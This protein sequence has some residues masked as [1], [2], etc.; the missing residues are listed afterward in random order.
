MRVLQVGMGG[1]GRNWTERVVPQV[2]AV[3]LVGY[4]DS[5]P[6]VL[7]TAQEQGLVA[8]KDCYISL[9]EALEKTDPDAVL[10]TAALSGHVPI[11]RQALEAGK[12]V[13][14]EKPFAPSVREGA[15]LV[16]LAERRHL[17][18]MVSQNYRFRPAVRAV[19]DIVSAGTLGALHT[20]NID[21]RKFSTLGPNGRSPH[22]SLAEP[23]LVDMS[24]HHFD[25]L[26]A[27]LR[28]QPVEIF[29]R[30][31][32]P[33][34]SWFDGPA[35]GTAVISFEGDLTVSYRGSWISPGPLT[36]WSGEWRMEFEQGEVWWTSQGPSADTPSEEYVVLRPVGQSEQLVE[37]PP[38]DLVDRAGSLAE[39]VAAVGSSRVPESSGA[40]NLGSLA[41]MYAAVDSAASRAAVNITKS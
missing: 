24:I 10:V 36:P 23:L 7:T 41:L 18:L 25:L 27:V 17:T 20:V 26:R 11:A 32:N 37:L 4:V 3:E 31:W 14:V 5:N 22:H 21:F 30:T 19:Q 1:W 6:A 13:L 40:E 8:T 39:F 2:S 35:E 12:H 33:D 15:E 16:E 28:L 34:W 9:S 29:C 38:M